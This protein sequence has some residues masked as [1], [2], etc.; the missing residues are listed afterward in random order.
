MTVFWNAAASAGP[1]ANNLHS[2]QTDNHSNTSSL[3]FTGRMLFL[4][5]NQQCQSTKG[6]KKTTKNIQNQIISTSQKF[7]KIT[8]T[9]LTK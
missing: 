4:T 9:K 3:N 8:E 7:T 5:P 6:E 1:Y 2:L